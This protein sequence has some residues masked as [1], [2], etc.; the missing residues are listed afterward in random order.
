MFSRVHSAVCKGV[1]GADVYVEADISR[2]LPGIY[3]VGLASTMVMESKERIRSAIMNSGLEYPRGRITVNLTPASLRKNGTGL[4]LP[5]AVAI[6][7]SYLYVDIDKASQYGIAGELS[8]EGGVLGIS[9][10]LPMILC[11][12]KSGLSKVI[13][14]ADNVSEAS[15]VSGIRIIPVRSLTECVS[16]INEGNAGCPDNGMFDINQGAEGM[17]ESARQSIKRSLEKSKAKAGDFADICGQEHAKRALTIAATGRHGLLMVG[18]PGCGKTML[19]SRLPGIMP[20][21]SEAERIETAVIYS[22]AGKTNLGGDIP[23]AR[24]FR[25]PH[26]S[27]GKAGLIGG[28]S[29]PVPGEIT[30]AH[31]G[32]LF[33]DE[34]CEFDTGTIESLR[35]PMEEKKIVHFRRGDSYAFPSDF[36]LVMAANPCPCG[37]YGDSRRMC[38]CTQTQLD[39]YRKKLSG[40]MMDRIDMRISMAK[41]EFSELNGSDPDIRSRNISTADMKRD[42]EAGIDFARRHGRA[43]YNADLTDSETD[44]YCALGGEEEMFMKS[45]YD[46]LKMTPR[47]YKKVLRVARTIADIAGS[48][49]IHQQHIAEALSYRMMEAVND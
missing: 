48:E 36:Q 7:A 25:S 21:M 10:V 28:G 5:I 45:A 26:C 27:I 29:I 17:I 16:V 42:V 18:S 47:S 49:H 46:A 4:D 1:E 15:L 38:K 12:K 34:V 39:K 2:G 24:P 44:V 8:L 13:I 23:L 11:M 3:I 6:L 35:T 33:L 22:A 14:P 30:L 31:N 20:E 41:V 43:G 19:A 32:V 40:P 37:F 9:G